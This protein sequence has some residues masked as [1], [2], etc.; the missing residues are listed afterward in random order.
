MA[1][2]LSS[3][4]CLCYGILSLAGGGLVSAAVSYPAIGGDYTQNFNTLSATGTTNAWAN[5]STL[6]GWHATQTSGATS[7]DYTVYQ[8]ASGSANQGNLL[9]LGTSGSSTDR[10]L[11][12]QNGNSTAPTVTTMYYGL[13]LTNATGSTLGSFSLSYAGE[14]WRV[15]DEE[16]RDKMVLQYQIFAAGAGSL[17]A[18][19]GWTTT[20]LGFDA[21]VVTTDSS[22]NLN[23]NNAAN[24]VVVNGGESGFTWADGAELWLR[25]SDASTGS[26]AGTG[27]TRSML[28]IDDVTFSA[29]VIPE[30]S[31]LLLSGL[32]VGLLAVRRRR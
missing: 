30:P 19:S 1:F 16:A 22:I 6:Q 29:D 20:S 14:Q 3:K 23:G 8:A 13:Q 24:R 18:T 11:G 31:G 15:V 25:W 2:P 21:P 17:L 9:S 32:G 10:A 5:D 27:G 7:T 26:T 4:V 28:G 12:G